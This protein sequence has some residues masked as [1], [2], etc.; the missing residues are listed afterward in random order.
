MNGQINLQNQSINQLIEELQQNIF[1]Q[2]I[3]E[4]LK[5]ARK[6]KSNPI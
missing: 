5:H 6:S 3:N 2:K 1:S 4:L